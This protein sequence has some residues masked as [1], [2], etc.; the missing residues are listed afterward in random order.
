MFP[1][2]VRVVCPYPVYLMVEPGGMFIL[3]MTPILAVVV[4]LV[5]EEV[6][7]TSF[8]LDMP[9]LHRHFCLTTG[10]P[11]RNPGVLFIMR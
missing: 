9:A 4:I 5:K 2:E 7:Y 11:R 3:G 10:I 6:F 1:I 8:F